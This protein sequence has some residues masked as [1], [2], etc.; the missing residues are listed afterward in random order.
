MERIVSVVIEGD[1]EIALE[2][3]ADRLVATLQEGAETSELPEG[4][5]I[6]D[7]FKYDP[8]APEEEEQT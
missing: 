7:I 8:D 6:V 1:D 2:Q 3:V 5:E 4:I